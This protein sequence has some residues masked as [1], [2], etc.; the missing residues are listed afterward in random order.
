MESVGLATLASALEEVI[1]SVPR[2]QLA[3]TGSTLLALLAAANYTP[4][5][6][7]A[8]MADE[9]LA[10][11][12]QKAF[13][14]K[15]AFEE[16]LVNRYEPALLHW[17]YRRTGDPERAL[18]LVQELYVKLLTGHT[19]ANYNPEQEFRPWLWRVVHNLWVSSLRRKRLPISLIADEEQPSRTPPP[20]EEAAAHELESRIDA[21][22]RELPGAQQQILREAMN[23]ASAGQI[24]E[25]LKI[26]KQRVFQLLFKAR[27]RVE[28]AVAQER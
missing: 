25:Q 6:V 5:D 13:L 2:E 21:V 20:I 28:Q 19:L 8:E 14:R 23:G 15:E 7:L 4:A 17:F 22:V 26:P 24:A 12:V 11:A 3:S 18:D 27:R 10:V 1:W 9:T 16:W